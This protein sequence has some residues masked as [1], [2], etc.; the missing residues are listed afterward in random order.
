MFSFIDYKNSHKN[1][2]AG[3]QLKYENMTCEKMEDLIFKKKV[4]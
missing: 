2:N 1:K 4:D 3:H